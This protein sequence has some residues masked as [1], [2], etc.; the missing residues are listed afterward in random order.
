M[1]VNVCVSISKKWKGRRVKAA[2]ERRKER[3]DINEERKMSIV[4]YETTSLSTFDDFL[5]T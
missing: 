1:C 5:Q 2:G 3:K 4:I